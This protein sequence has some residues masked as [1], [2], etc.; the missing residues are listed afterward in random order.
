MAE[1]PKDYMPVVQDRISKQPKKTIESRKSPLFYK[2]AFES[3][4]K[5]NDGRST[6]MMLQKTGLIQLTIK[7]S[8]RRTE[9]CFP[10][11]YN[12]VSEATKANELDPKDFPKIQ[13]KIHSTK[14]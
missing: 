13:R 6:Q 7:Q 5:P 3:F 8:Q 10:Y 1:S 11:I 14:R 9:R 12:L 4:E 2:T